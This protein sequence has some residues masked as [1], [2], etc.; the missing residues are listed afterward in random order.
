MILNSNNLLVK[1]T[2]F[3]SCFLQVSW[4]NAFLVFTC[5]SGTEPEVHIRLQHACNMH[6]QFA[7]H[8][9]Y[10]DILFIDF[11]T[12]LSLVTNSGKLQR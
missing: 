1:K 8:Q 6:V 7:P 11:A 10:S 12:E 5:D 3:V 4:T 2:T 9:F